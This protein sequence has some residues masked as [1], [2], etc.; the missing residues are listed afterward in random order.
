MEIEKDK[1]ISALAT[2]YLNVYL[3]NVETNAANVIKFKGYM[4][5]GLEAGQK[6]LNYDATLAIYAKE[7]VHSNEIDDFL[8][9]LSCK[10]LLE[11]FK[12]TDTYEYTYMIYENYEEHY[13]VATYRKI[14]SVG[15]PLVVIAGFK[16][17]DNYLNSQKLKVEEGINKAYETISSI[18]SCMYRID[19]RKRKYVEIKTTKEIK[20]LGFK[21]EGNFEE[22]IIKMIYAVCDEKYIDALLDVLDINKFEERLISNHCIAYEFLLKNTGWSRL[23]VI[24]EKNNFDKLTN[25]ILTIEIIEDTV[26]K[27]ERINQMAQTDYLTG[28]LNKTFGE[29]Y[30][31]SKIKNQ[32]AGV[33]ILFDVNNYVA[34]KN[35]YGIDE[36]N[37]M[38]K[39]VSNILFEGS[40]DNDI[41]YRFNEEIFAIYASGILNIND[42]DKYINKFIKN[43]KNVD[44]Y[45]NENI[46][47]SISVGCA[48]NTN[49]RSFESLY[50][51]ADRALFE[52]KKSEN[53]KIVYIN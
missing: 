26:R 28:L 24:K 32:E 45:E 21:S 53:F 41:L 11:V 48:F 38:I 33:Y 52:S 23:R 25:V 17:I 50:K 34:I 30:A 43:M 22:F 36:A 46:K 5:G 1:I 2:D 19:V 8:E 49:N 14:S 9:K 15:E 44:I 10:S 47:L 37:D 6:N 51:L 18:Y 35:K 16:C 40:T 4:F 29:K 3:I 12:S 20:D 31:I 7:R 27:T 13:Y 39:R 42:A